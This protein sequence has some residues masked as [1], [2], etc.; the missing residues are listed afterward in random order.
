MEKAQVISVQGAGKPGDGKNAE[1][2]DW[3]NAIDGNGD[4]C[5]PGAAAC[6]CST[7]FFPMWPCGL[8]TVNENQGV[9]VLHMGKLAAV[10]DEPGLTCINPCCTSK[11]MVDTKRISMD[12][13]N[14]K[15]IDAKGNPVIISAIIV[16]RITNVVRAALE[17][18]NVP[19]FV[20]SQGTAVMKQVASKYPYEARGDEPSLKSE[21]E[22]VGSEMVTRLGEKVK[23]VGVTVLDFLLNE[24]S[25]APE[26][27]GSMLV[28]Q[29]A[30]A[31]LDARTMVVE[32]AVSIASRAA[33]QLR[34]SGITMQESEKARMVSNLMCI[35]CGDANVQPTMNISS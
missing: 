30:E 25:Y 12:L 17:V 35:I 13:P 7:L 18:A 11:R 14:T 22:M 10:I 21:A 2:K 6:I 1:G 34:E 3:E 8:T 24:L 29:Q 33:D 20:R 32:G 9:V 4:L 26:I 19:A 27:A 16:Y 23:S 31:L 5:C 15:V 28:R